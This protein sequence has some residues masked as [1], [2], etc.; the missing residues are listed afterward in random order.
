MNGMGL[1]LAIH[2]RYPDLPV[3]LMSGY[4]EVEQEPTQDWPWL[5]RLRKPCTQQDI[6]LAL[7]AVIEARGVTALAT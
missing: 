3:I 4:M 7:Q 6:G 1:A 5:G 2:T